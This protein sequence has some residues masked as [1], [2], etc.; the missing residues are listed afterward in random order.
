MGNG[1]CKQEIENN[2]DG[3]P[4]D[5][6]TEEQEKNDPAELR[7]WAKEGDATEL[8]RLLKRMPVKAI[9]SGAKKSEGIPEEEG[10]T[11]LHFAA[12]R[13]SLPCCELLVLYGAAV[14][15]KGAKGATP[16]HATL[17]AGRRQVAHF[18]L[19][20]GADINAKDSSGSSPFLCVL[21]SGRKRLATWLLQR[22]GGGPSPPSPAASSVA[23]DVGAAN[24]EGVSPLTVAARHGWWDLL[25]QLVG[26]AADPA[27]ALN[28]RSGEG[29]TPLGW[30]LK[31]GTAGVLAGGELVRLASALL[32]KGASAVLPLF[33]EQIPPLCLAAATGEAALL[34]ALRAKGASLEPEATKD[35]MGRNVLHYAA[36]KGR[37][38]L[39]ALLQSESVPGLTPASTDLAGNTP[40]HLAAQRGH[41][42]VAR[43]LLQRSDDPA[44]AIMTPNREGVTVF[45]LFL[46]AG[47]APESQEGVL[48]M[49]R[50]LS[51][52]QAATP[53][54]AKEIV[55]ATP[56]LLAVGSHQEQVVAELLAAGHDPNQANTEGDTPLSRCLAGATAATAAADGAIFRLLVEKGAK[57]ESA[58]ETCHPLLA[59]C[60][61]P[62]SR[63]SEAV[64]A[65]L[66][67]Q[68]GGD[69]AAIPW[70]GRVDGAGRGPLHLAAMYDNA[71]MVRYLIEDVKMD[72]EAPSGEGL[73]PLMYAAWGCSSNAMRVLLN[74]RADPRV[75]DP[76]GAS[77]LS[78]CLRLDRP[79]S[80]ACAAMLLMLGAP[81]EDCVDGRGEG[82][83]HR[84]VR[85]GC[86]EFIR[87]WCRYGGNVCLLATTAD[88]ADDLPEAL[89]EAGVA[90]AG[91]RGGPKEDYMDDKPEPFEAGWEAEGGWP[92]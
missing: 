58:S 7:R 53:V 63:F 68:A 32:D 10:H 11:A 81:A 75:K 49:L 31:Y 60:K 90:G 2:P 4:K 92:L 15:A 80:L 33:K 86:S 18:L 69:P 55:I 13:G 41:A 19:E 42:D 66:L 62:L 14:N 12:A 46:K 22:C 36:A 37:Q 91:G 8:E 73:T 70:A 83:L 26:M 28:T 50:Q 23:L 17:D 29:E 51:P 52:E 57:M 48:W 74:R 45:H 39:C 76:T 61:N 38:S 3:N 72:V 64:V 25:E 88:A 20:H 84:A 67:D 5:P 89:A 56:L 35:I 43:E 77:V 34:A 21:L 79:E 71:Y 6:Q 1:C 30:A 16:L 24:K 40:L 44:S 54:G 78:Y 59:I 82:L 27:Q 9:R 47:P 85:Y 65:L 87:L